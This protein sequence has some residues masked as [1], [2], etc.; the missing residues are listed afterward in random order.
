MLLRKRVGVRASEFRIAHGLPFVRSN[1][2]DTR[3]ADPRRFGYAGG[4]AVPHGDMSDGCAPVSA[5]YAALA[6]LE[7]GCRVT[8]ERPSGAGWFV[9]SDFRDATHGRFNDLLT[10]IGERARTGDRRTIAASFALR[11]GWASAMA[12]APYLLFQCVPDVSL[13]NVSFKFHDSSAFERGALHEPRGIV[14]A[15]DPH[16]AHPSM[17]VVADADAL[18]RALRDALVAQSSPVVDALFA[19]SGFSRRGTWGL[20]TSSWA[21]QFTALWKDHDDQRGVGPLLDALFAGH[22]EVAAMRPAMHAV[23]YAGAIHLY[24]RRAS[25]C[26]YYLL[27]AGDLCASCPLVS[28]DER[29]QRNRDWMRSQYGRVLTR[30][31]AS[32]RD[33]S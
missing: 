29:R 31:T 23:E 17:S 1:R 16:A 8:I 33:Q 22:D 10:L 25:C 11:F 14:I 19:W 3:A 12:I 7:V 20:L 5:V 15:G 32:F 6:T 18:L 26:R 13:D 30:R 9:G 2:L 28:D 24:Q 21:S 4:D 27:P